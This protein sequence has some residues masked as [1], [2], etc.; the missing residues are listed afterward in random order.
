MVIV[1]ETVL[2]VVRDVQ[3]FP[4]IIIVVPDANALTPSRGNKT[5]LRDDIR[6]SPIM[7]VV[8]QVVCGSLIGW[9]SFQC[10]AVHYEN[11]WPSVVVIIKNGHS[12][13]RRLDDVFLGFDSAKHIHRGKP[14]F[15]RDIRKICDARIVGNFLRRGLRRQ[16][17]AEQEDHCDRPEQY[18]LYEWSLDLRTATL[19]AFTLGASNRSVDSA[20]CDIK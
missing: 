18:F 15:F 1:I 13:S 6:E 4:A 16:R 17:A 2:P 5:G 10:G 11:I 12:R 20:E 19:H 7:I 9:E 8:I 3:I 14:R